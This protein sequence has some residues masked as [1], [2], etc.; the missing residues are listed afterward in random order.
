MIRN[1]RGE[2]RRRLLEEEK[3]KS[4]SEDEFHRL[5][6]QLQ[7]ITDEYIEKIDSVSSKKEQEIRGE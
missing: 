1:I 7:K 4:I 6:E 3:N 2:Q 5:E